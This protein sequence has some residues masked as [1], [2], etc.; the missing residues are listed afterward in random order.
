MIQLQR[1]FISK[2]LGRDEQRYN[3]GLK[4][5]RFANIL[6]KKEALFLKKLETND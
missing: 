5:S 6:R 1:I 2:T 3:D 4:M